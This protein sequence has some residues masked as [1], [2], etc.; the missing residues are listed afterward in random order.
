MN[1]P[2]SEAVGIGAEADVKFLSYLPAQS[3]GTNFG[4]VMCGA[5]CCYDNSRDDSGALH[6]Y[7]TLTTRSLFRLW[8]SRI[9]RPPVDSTWKKWHPEGP[10]SV[11]CSL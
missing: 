6:F 1:Q 7:V 11:C 8:M 10:R 9:G 4:G 5:Q 2:N 3:A